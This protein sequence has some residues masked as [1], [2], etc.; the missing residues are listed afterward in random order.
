MTATDIIR[1][2]STDTVPDD[3]VVTAWTKDDHIVQGIKHRSLPMYAVQF[4]P[5]R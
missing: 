1:W 4:H 5:D 3:L 2:P